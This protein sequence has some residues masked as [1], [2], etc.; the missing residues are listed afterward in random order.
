MDDLQSQLHRDTLDRLAKEETIQ[1]QT[2]QSP[3]ACNLQDLAESE[4]TRE[5]ELLGYVREASLERKELSAGY[6]LRF[7][8]DSDAVLKVAEFVTLER[9]C[10][11]FLNFELLIEAEGGPVWLKVTGRSGVKEFLDTVLS[12]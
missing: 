4:R 9:L 11:P 1:M 7:P 8:G 2:K 10:C 12:K 5:Q 3:I 6:A